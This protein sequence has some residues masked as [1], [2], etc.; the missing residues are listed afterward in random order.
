MPSLDYVSQTTQN[1]SVTYIDMPAKTGL[2][3]VNTSTGAKTPSS[4]EA[5]SNGGSGWTQIPIEATLPAAQYYLLAQGPESQHLAQTVA[6]S[7][8]ASTSMAKPKAAST[9]KST[10]KSKSKSE[11]KPKAKPKSKPK[12]K[13]KS[14]SKS[15][16]KSKAKPKSKSKAKR[17]RR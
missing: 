14:K 13:P 5:L 7:V 8:S 3:F 9:S 15:A 16:S 1:V 11:S 17:L 6:F 10:P 12:P 4:S 2:V